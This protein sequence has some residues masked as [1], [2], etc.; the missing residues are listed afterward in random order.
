MRKPRPDSVLDH[1]PP[2]QDEQL[3]E[4]IL[5]RVPYRN[6]AEAMKT[7]YEVETSIRA[8]SKYW[9]K[10]GAE[11]WKATRHNA[12]QMAKDVVAEASANPGTFSKAALE[13][14]EQK[15]FALSMD[16]QSS[17]GELKGLVQ[18]LLKTQ[19][20][21]IRKRD[22]ELAIERMAFDRE[23]FREHMKS[24]IDLGFDALFVEVEGN[25][26]AEKLFKKMRASVTGSV[27]NA[28]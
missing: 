3:M 25:P 4:W 13:A 20:Q 10:W 23:K 17:A 6:I 19:D 27:E 28:A 15:A 2:D 9:Q 16:P 8:I 22:Q 26:E 7:K 5:G 18:M 24:A 1:L 14:I 12:L 21:A 11:H